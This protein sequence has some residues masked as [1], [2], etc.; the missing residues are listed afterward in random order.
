MAGFSAR[1][2]AV[3]PTGSL[4]P[5]LVEV[6][7]KGVGANRVE[8]WLRTGQE[9][10]PAATWPAAGRAPGASR[11]VLDEGRPPAIPGMDRVLAVRHQG[12]LLGAL[13]VAKPASEPFSPLEER[14]LGDLAG[15]AGLAVQGERMAAAPS[16]EEVLPGAAE[17][18]ARGLGAVHG[19]A[20]LLLEDGSQ[21]RC[22]PAGPPEPAPDYAMAVAYRGETVGQLA[23]PC[24]P[25]GP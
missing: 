12:E 9:L 24:R 16:P 23:A 8:M 21:V 11:L 13:G 22:W 20:S 3:G 7:G 14:L 18:A 1:V 2:A 10:W 19:Q 17:A 25:G 15:Q 5:R 4:L 6:V